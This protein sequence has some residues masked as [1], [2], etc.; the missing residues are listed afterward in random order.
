M[1]SNLAH[2]IFTIGLILVGAVVFVLGLG[3]SD[4]QAL[5]AAGCWDY[6]AKTSLSMCR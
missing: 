3:A 5:Q 6:Q 1:Y 2:R 4:I